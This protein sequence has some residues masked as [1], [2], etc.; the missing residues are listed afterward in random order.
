M[1]K[2]QIRKFAP[3]T[4]FNEKQYQ[5]S[6]PWVM[7]NPISFLLAL[8]LCCRCVDGQES[9]F[10]GIGNHT[11]KISTE[12]N[13][14]QAMFDQG[15]AFLYSFNHD[16]AIRSFHSAARHDPESAVV[17]WA[18]A[19]TNG[20]HINFPFVDDVHADRL[21]DLH[22]SLGHLVHMPSHI[23]ARMGQWQRAIHANEKAI[24]ADAAYR[25]LS[26]NQNSIVP[27]WR[28]IIT[29]WHLLP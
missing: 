1:Y 10:R 2:L 21:R 8:L 23:D 27:T 26:P 29:C 5:A 13:E 22:Q 17:H 19:L 9:R 18:I 14:T 3:M 20:P 7:L 6:I 4:L 15:L 16:E 11:R 24:Q 12:S 25:A 28:T